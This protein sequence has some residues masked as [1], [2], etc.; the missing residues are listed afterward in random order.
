MNIHSQD[1]DLDRD[2]FLRHADVEAFVAWL[3]VNL[4]V[5]QVDLRISRSAFVQNPVNARLTG[6]EAVQ[7]TYWWRGDWATVS[8]QLSSYRR[9]LR[10]AVDEGSQGRTYSTCLEILGWGNVPNSAPYLND[11]RG[12]GLLVHYLKDIEP[13]LTPTGNQRLSDLTRIAIPRFNSGL[14]KVHALLDDAGSPIYDGRVGAAIATLY[15]LYR[16]SGAAAGEANHRMFGWGPGYVTPVGNRLRHIRNPRLLGQGFNGT[17]QLLSHTSPHIWARRQVI[18][19]WIMRAVLNRTGLFSAD[20]V[21]MAERCHAFESALFQLGYDVRCLVPG[22]WL[23]IDPGR[24]PG[25]A[26]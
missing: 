1:A 5:L 20:G 2:D 22:G 26:K 25:A 7:A 12:R 15:H 14:T 17:P 23:I 19:G 11:L 16:R 4:P 21:D 10:M 18:L 8:Q 3:V 24:S 6:I 13:L 9:D